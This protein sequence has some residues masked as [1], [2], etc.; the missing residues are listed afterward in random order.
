MAGVARASS[1]ATELGALHVVALLL[2]DDVSGRDARTYLKDWL[3]DFPNATTLLIAMGSACESQGTGRWDAIT[4]YGLPTVEA[5]E[6]QYLNDA[7]RYF[8]AA[9]ARQPG[10]AE[11]LLHKA[12]VL[13]VLHDTTAAE[14]AARAVLTMDPAPEW[15]YLALLTLGGLRANAADRDGAMHAI[16]DALRLFPNAQSGTLALAALQDANNQPEVAGDI[17]QRLMRGSPTAGVT[18]PWWDYRFG[19]AKKAMVILNALRAEM[20]K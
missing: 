13:K 7:L 4:D 18:D 6:Y 15:R 12:V 20:R 1:D 8:D 10:S 2:L 11:A 9:L 16:G 5:T 3:F 17:V 14:H 19:H